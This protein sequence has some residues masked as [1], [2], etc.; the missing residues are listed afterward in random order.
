MK[1]KITQTIEIP[2]SWIGRINIIKM[3]ILPKAIYRFNAIPEKYQWHFSQNKK[4]QKNLI[5]METQKTLNSQSNPEKEKQ[6]WKNQASWLQTTVQS[7]SHQNSM[8]SV[9]KKIHR[10]MEQDGKPETNP[11]TYG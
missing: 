11:C 1:L 3:T 8:V 9:P 2:C 4:E 6:T 10:S 5:C 7:Y